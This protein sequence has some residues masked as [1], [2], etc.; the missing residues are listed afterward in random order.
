MQSTKY[1]LIQIQS[2]MLT[3]EKTIIPNKNSIDHFKKRTK[4]NVRFQKTNPT[5]FLHIER[6]MNK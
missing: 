4:I 6:T 1:Q 2:I 5:L 3:N